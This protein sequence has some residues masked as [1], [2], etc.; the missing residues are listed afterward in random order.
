MDKIGKE[1][2]PYGLK[3]IIINKRLFLKG[4]SFKNGLFSIVVGKCKK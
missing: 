2:F 3:R 1:L 4:S